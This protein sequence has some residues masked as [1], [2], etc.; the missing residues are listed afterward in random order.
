MNWQ[1]KSFDDLS[2]AELYKILRLRAEIF[3]VEQNCVYQDCDGYDQ[4]AHHVMAW[5]DENLVAYA[6][7]FPEGVK[8]KQACISRV[9]T[10]P[11]VRG[12]GVGNELIKKCIEEITTRFNTGNITISAQKYLEKFYEGHG[13]SVVGDTYLED[14]IPHIE[15][16]RKAA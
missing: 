13:F 16:T 4:K 3:V 8:Y 12:Q 7:I 1:I 14:N 15:M 6:R 11:L 5:Q 2:T 9:V 10:S